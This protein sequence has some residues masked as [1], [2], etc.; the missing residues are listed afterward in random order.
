M[1]LVVSL[2]GYGCSAATP[3]LKS[4]GVDFRGL[5]GADA[6]AAAPAPVARLAAT[7][8]D[9]PIDAESSADP[10]VP[11]GRLMIY[12]A[13]YE[14]IV[15]AR[16]DSIDRFLGWVEEAGGYLESRDDAEVTCR[17][18]V[19]R[20][21]PLLER[22]PA[23]GRVVR[24]SLN[25]RDV[26][27]EVMDLDLRID[28]AERARVRL[29]DLLERATDTEAILQIEKE[30]RRLTE[31]IERMRGAVKFLRQ[32]I[33][34]STLTVVFHTDAPA[35]TSRRRHGSRFPWIEALGVD[36]VLGAF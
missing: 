19:D 9:E 28:N 14:L 36:R 8:E 26:T 29:L 12:S 32:Q 23:L 21:F 20:F 24:E 35:V 11:A 4:T 10:A 18:P 7:Y 34:Y 17:I 5:G 16:D 22:V 2:G 25:A 1:V 30:L 3:T 15:P 13:R 33:S 6:M 31:E 27:R